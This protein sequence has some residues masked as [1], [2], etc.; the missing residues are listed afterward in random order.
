MYGGL[1]A[2]AN[3]IITDAIHQTLPLWNN[4]QTQGVYVYADPKAIDTAA[5]SATVTVES[6]VQNETAAAQAVTL[7]MEVF[8]HDGNSVGQATAAPQTVA[9][10]AK[11]VITA[12]KALT[13]VHFWAPNYPYLYTVRSTIS[14]GGKAGDSTDI[15]FGIRKFSLSATNGFKINGHSTYLPGFA[16]RTV[17]DWAGSGIPQNWMTEYDYLLMKGM[18]HNFIRPMHVA[19]VRHMVDSADRLGI[20]M[21]VPAGDGEGCYDMTR[22][23]Q[24]LALMQAEVI[25]FRNN[26]SVAFYEACNSGLTEAQITGM[27]DIKN[28][29][30]SHGSRY[31]GDRGTD[32]QN[33]PSMEYQ[34]PMDGSGQS[35]TMP[36]WSAEY[37]REESPRRAWDAYSPIWDPRAQKI[38][39][40]GGYVKVVDPTRWG[41]TLETANGN[42]I[43]QYPLCDFRQNSMEDM[44]LCNVYKYWQGYSKSN[45]VEDV[46]TR[47]SKGIQIGSAKII[48]ADSNTDG[49][50][51]LT[52]VARVGGV[53]DAVR[54]IK[55]NY[56]VLKV[57]SSLVPDIHIIGH[58][59]YAA[60]TTKTVYV[61]SNTESVTLAVYD[62]NGSL[63]KDYGK[64]AVDMQM[65]AGNPNHYIFAFPNVA[66]PGGQDQGGGAQRQAPPSPT[67]ST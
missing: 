18:N 13:G 49:R 53:V 52:E 50:L 37:S 4:L 29:W 56:Y 66:V 38:V 45:F 44:S 3:L 39:A 19:P 65:G 11:V 21:V 34:S 60:G 41:T 63:I 31:M 23:P 40:S 27:V 7:S 54:I 28:K 24:H 62:A 32:P 59:N 6:E 58:W 17:M 64:G 36:L 51:Q 57:A 47:T 9:A 2:D 67:T 48:F 25:Y 35:P 5:K 14:V 15:P 1:F 33:E 10:G 61:A 16:P 43:A 46:A 20:V 42:G 55:E 12:Q 22:W 30:D 8:D 26:P